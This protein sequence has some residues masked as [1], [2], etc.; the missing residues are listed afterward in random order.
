MTW[1]ILT[2][3]SIILWGITD[4]LFKKSLNHTDS[5][6]QYKTFIS[7]GL[8]MAPAGCVAALCSDWFRTFLRKP[9]CLAP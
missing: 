2:I 4:I 8:V 9:L 1:F 6:S 5:L 3:S 7:I